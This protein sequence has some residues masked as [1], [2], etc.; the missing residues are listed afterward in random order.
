V[1]RLTGSAQEKNRKENP[2]KAAHD[3]ENVQRFSEQIIMRNPTTKARWLKAIAL[4]ACKRL[5]STNARR[6][7]FSTINVNG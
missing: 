2:R 4:L 6:A 3:P 5:R 7:Y 1:W